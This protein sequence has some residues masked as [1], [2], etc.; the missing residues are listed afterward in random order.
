MD[1]KDNSGI[2]KHLMQQILQ[3]TN[4]ILQKDTYQQFA[5]ELL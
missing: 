4:A 2:I 1:P 5:T 3:E